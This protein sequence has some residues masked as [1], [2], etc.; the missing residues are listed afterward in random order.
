MQSSNA[1]LFDTEFTRNFEIN[2]TEPILHSPIYFEAYNG[3]Q[4]INKQ[5]RIIERIPYEKINEKK[6]KSIIKNMNLVHPNITTMYEWYTDGMY[7]YF[8]HESCLEMDLAHFIGS[9]PLKEVQ[10]AIIARQVLLALNYCHN[11]KVICEG[12]NLSRIFFPSGY[13]ALKV[14]IA[15]P[16]VATMIKQCAIGLLESTELP[17]YEAPEV[18]EGK[19]TTKSPVWSLGAIT[20]RM[21]TGRNPFE[22]KNASDVK[23]DIIKG[24]VH[25]PQAIF[26]SRGECQDFISKLLTS[27]DKRITPEEALH[28]PWIVRNTAEYVHKETNVSPAVIKSLVK[29]SNMEAIKRVILGFLVSTLETKE[30]EAATKAFTTLNKDG[31]GKLTK[32]EIKEGI[33]AFS[34]EEDLIEF[35]D[36]ADTDKTG[37]ID[38]REFCKAALATQIFT[39]KDKLARGLS[40]LDKNK[41]GFIRSEKLLEALKPYN[42]I[43]PHDELKKLIENIEINRD[44]KISLKELQVILKEK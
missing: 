42:N 14:K 30:V 18:F 22:G 11:M 21:V 4:S 6:M 23:A 5:K 37:Y 40:F 36:K 7:V 27:A 12:L 33:K 9:K 35:L 28:H 15:N 16:E 32:E 41:N 24:S 38:Y 8:V 13:E 17:Y 2:F 43:V 10:A 34:V 3:L 44:G 1:P 26:G 19:A 39:N 31:D 29:F 20:Y 25:F